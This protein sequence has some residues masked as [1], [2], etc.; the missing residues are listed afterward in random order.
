M[1]LTNKDIQ[2]IIALLQASSFDE[3]IVETDRYKLSLRR[4]GGGWTQETN[5]ARREHTLVA[6]EE[7]QLRQV[8]LEPGMAAIY[9]PLTGTFYRAPKPGAEPFVA[10]G[11]RVEKDTVVAII[12]TMKLMN[13]VHAGVE[14]VVTEVCAENA[15]FVEQSRIL[16]KVRT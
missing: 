5:T 12:E 11:S 9:P 7:P 3:L 16:M 14:G 6:E 13:S 15:E 8:A 10:V 2:E 1:N 4:S